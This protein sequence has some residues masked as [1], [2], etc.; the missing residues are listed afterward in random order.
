MGATLRGAR[1]VMG[2]GPEKETGD[3]AAVL[4]KLGA[5]QMGWAR[6]NVVQRIWVKGGTSWV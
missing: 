1:I 3:G 5:W 6:A 2:F 4:P